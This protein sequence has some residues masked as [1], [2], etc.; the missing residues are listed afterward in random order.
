VWFVIVSTLASYIPSFAFYIPYLI[1]PDRRSVRII[2][3]FPHEY[4]VFYYC[5]PSPSTLICRIFY[6]KK[7]S[8]FVH[9]YHYRYHHRSVVGACSQRTT[10]YRQITSLGNYQCALS[11][12]SAP[13]YTFTLYMSPLQKLYVYCTLLF[14]NTSNESWFSVTM[15]QLRFNVPKWTSIGGYRSIVL[16]LCGD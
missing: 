11:L 9:Q 12:M 13:F 8:V 15:C 1:C 6:P 7:I 2:T 4:E 16:P 3:R 5:S 10:K 14:H